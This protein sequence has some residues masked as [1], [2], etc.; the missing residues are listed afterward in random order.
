MDCIQL[1]APSFKAIISMCSIWCDFFRALTQPNATLQK[2]ESIS[3]S[4][5]MVEQDYPGRQVSKMIHD[6][7]NIIINDK[8]L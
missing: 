4:Q 8:M 6:T 5:L 1:Q 2:Q 3:K 7:H